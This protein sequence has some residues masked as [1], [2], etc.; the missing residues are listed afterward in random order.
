MNPVRWREVAP[1]ANL[2]LPGEE[3]DER[4]GTLLNVRDHG[5][6]DGRDTKLSVPSDTKLLSDLLRLSVGH[7]ASVRRAHLEEKWAEFDQAQVNLELTANDA[8]ELK[9]EGT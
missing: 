3:V 1:K 5:Q 9:E 2:I 8:K 7:R 6:S 4:V